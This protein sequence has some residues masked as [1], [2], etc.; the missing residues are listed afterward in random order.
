M[1]YIGGS[2]GIVP[3]S[4]STTNSQSFNGDGS[5]VAFT[6]NRP[7]ANVKDIEVVVN[8]VQQSPYDSSY[9]VS[10]NTLTFSSAPSTGTGNIYITYR[11][12]PIGSLTDPNAYT[13][14]QTDALIAGVD[15]TSRVAKTGDTMTGALSVTNSS[16]TTP[17]GYFQNTS[18]SGD[19][20]ALIVRG[21]ANNTNTVGTFEVQSYGGNK[22]LK[23]DGNG[24]VTMPYQPLFQGY[25]NSIFEV[26]SGSSTKIT[27]SIGVNYN[28]GG[29]W[30]NYR[31]TCPV[32]GV[33]EVHA[34]FMKRTGTTQAIHLDVSINGQGGN[35]LRRLRSWEGTGYFYLS[36][37]WLVNLSANDYI[38][39]FAYAGSTGQEIYSEHSSLYI[40]LIG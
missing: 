32:S 9:T 21:G 6:L 4:F 20:P 31:F 35:A 38:E 15:L 1:S 28:V 13:K 25:F 16:S 24:R 29:H 23:V 22:H 30:S 3:V 19:S 8:N 10:D 27:S 40:K 14:S 39:F 36:N 11:D 2:G 12:F 33:Y 7:V 26:A 18:G 17:T 37:T 5:T 34:G